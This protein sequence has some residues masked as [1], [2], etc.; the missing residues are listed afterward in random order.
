MQFLIL[1]FDSLEIIVRSNTFNSLVIFFMKDV[2]ML[3]TN[4]P[5]TEKLPIT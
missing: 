1:D 2:F 4:G 5:T 3:L